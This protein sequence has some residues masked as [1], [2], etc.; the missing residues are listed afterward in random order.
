[1]EPPCAVDEALGQS[2]PDAHAAGVNL[3]AVRARRAAAV[4]ALEDVRQIIFRDSGPAVLHAQA[5]G[6]C[7]LAHAHAHAPARRRVLEAVLEHVLEGFRRPGKVSRKAGARL[8]LTHKL[9]TRQLGGDLQR[10]GRARHELGAV[11]AR[12]R[13]A[14][15][16]CVD[17]R[18]LEQARH[19]PLH[20]AL[21]PFHRSQ[22]LDLARMRAVGDECPARERR[23]ER[24]GS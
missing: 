5:E 12:P 8:H 18:E 4:E 14:H 1:M 19:E 13:E 6:Q 9:H 23:H 21:E 24:E 10:L 15:H 11:N 20:A 2:E 7:V 3:G 22:A 17:A 16:A